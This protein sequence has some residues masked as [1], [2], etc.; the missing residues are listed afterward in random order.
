[1]YSNSIYGPVMPQVSMPTQIE[2]REKAG[3]TALHDAPAMPYQPLPSHCDTKKE[4]DR[5]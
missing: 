2:E 5:D 3:Y 1:M 4:R